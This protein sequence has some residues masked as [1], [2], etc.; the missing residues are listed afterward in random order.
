MRIETPRLRLRSWEERD[1]GPLA[2]MY[3]DPEVMRDYGAPFDRAASDLRFE[4]YVAAFARDGYS[5]WVVES[6]A[7]DFLGYT[8]VMTSAYPDHP[9]GTHTEIGWRLVRRAWGHGYASE[10]ARAS[11]EDVFVRVG[12]KEVLAYTQPDNPSSQAVMW[13]LGLQRDP[14]RDFTVSLQGQSWRQ[15]VWVARRA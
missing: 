6:P 10:A 12:L 2:A 13:R 11:L 14:S 3:A 8:G 1:R 15:L 7:G 4:R 5:R 9:L